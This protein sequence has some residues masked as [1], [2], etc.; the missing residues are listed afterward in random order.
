MKICLF[1][2]IHGNKVAFDAAYERIIDEKADLNIFLGDLCG[3]Y[4]DEI[5]IYQKL[6]GL[7]NFIALRG[8][9]DN[10]FISAAQGEQGVVSDYVS[11]YGSSIKHFLAKDHKAMVMWLKK[12]PESFVDEKAGFACYHG[13]PANHTEGYVYPDTDPAGFTNDAQR[14]I[15]LGHTHYP[16]HRMVG[17]TM[18]VNPGSLGQPRQGGWPTYAVVTLPEQKVAF[19]EIQYDV[20][21]VVKDLEHKGEEK[22]YL[23]DVLLRCY[24][25]HKK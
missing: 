25:Q 14:N 21:L 9:H 10:M 1:S 15:F 3:Y 4:F 17:N 20:S 2:D 6:L 13:S 16:M 11:R 18:I 24:V 23:K 19:K 12:N 22:P 7:P 8:N 5:A